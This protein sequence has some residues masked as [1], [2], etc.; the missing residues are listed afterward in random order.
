MPT[1]RPTLAPYQ[2][3]RQTI[4]PGHTWGPIYLGVPVIEHTFWIYLLY[5]FPTDR[6]V[7]RKDF[8]H[9]ESAGKRWPCSSL[10]RNKSSWGWREEKEALSH[11]KLVPIKSPLT[12]SSRN[13]ASVQFSRSVVTPRI[14]APEAS[15]SI[16][17]SLFTQTHVL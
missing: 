14:A 10:R 2:P 11:R 6:S 3:H 7:L 4:A 13:L 9:N 16:T 12:S 8:L 5:N 1:T 17:N 15:L